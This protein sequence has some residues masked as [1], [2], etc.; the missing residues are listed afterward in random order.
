MPPPSYLRYP[1]NLVVLVHEGEWMNSGS[2]KVLTL[3]GSTPSLQPFVYK[4]LTQVFAIDGRGAVRSVAGQGAYVQPASTCDGVVGG[5]SAAAWRFMDRNLQRAYSLEVQCAVGNR[6][7]DFNSMVHPWAILL[8]SSTGSS[9][10]WFVVPV[11]RTDSTEQAPYL[12]QAGRIEWPELQGT[13]AETAR[14]AL[15]SAR[16]DL[17]VSVVVGAYMTM[18]FVNTRVRIASSNDGKVAQ[19]PRIG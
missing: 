18:D 17:A 19:V 13:N 9:T 5:S 10:G 8:G 3:R 11:A 4:D 16:P 1:S 2:M 6:R 15:A 12:G 14:M 7:I